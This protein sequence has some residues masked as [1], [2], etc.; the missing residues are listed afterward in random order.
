MS[1]VLIVLALFCSVTVELAYPDEIILKDGKKIECANVWEQ[2]G[3]MTIPESYR[4]REQTYG[5]L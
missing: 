5:Y 2:G 4:G 3:A 1:F